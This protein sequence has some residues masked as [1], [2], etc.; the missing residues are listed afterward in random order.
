MLT[1][2]VT[3]YYPPE[4]DQAQMGAILDRLNDTRNLANFFKEMRNLMK[5]TATGD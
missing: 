4:L 5:K 2:L 3:E 1:F